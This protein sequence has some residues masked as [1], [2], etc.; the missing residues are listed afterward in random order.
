LPALDHLQEKLGGNDF[1]I[2]AVSLD[3]DLV[4]ARGL[5][6]DL[7]IESMKFFNQSADELG[8][9]FP[10]D[11]LPTTILIDRDSQAIGLLRSSLNWNDDESVNLI[12]RIIDGVTSDTLRSEKSQ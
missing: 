5:F 6:A 4:V 7:S 1:V 12:E 3:E 8:K 10:V 2:I 9:S 11:V